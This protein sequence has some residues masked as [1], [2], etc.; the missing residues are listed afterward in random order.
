M[1]KHFVTFYSPGTFVP[2]ERTMP[3]DSWNEQDAVKMARGIVERHSAKPFGFRFTTRARGDNDL[4]S[5]VVDQSGMYY[6]GGKVRTAEEVLAGTD[7]KEDTLRFNVRVNGIK[8]VIVNDNSWR[9]TGAMNDDD[10]LLD[11]NLV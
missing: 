5:K 2:E 9:F 11:V 4:D 1:Q 7:P 10:V 8:R 6:L 3:I